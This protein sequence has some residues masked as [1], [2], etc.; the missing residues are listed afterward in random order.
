MIHS[1]WR[2]C[3]PARQ[4]AVVRG[5]DVAWRGS[6]VTAEQARFFETFGYLLIR[7]AFSPDEM[8]TLVAEFVT[9]LAQD[10]H[11]REFGGDRRQTVYALVERRLPW[12]IEDD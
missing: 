12:L 9:G 1:N 7:R 6:M 3:R 11:G 10:R 2:A 5:T 4:Q 8:A